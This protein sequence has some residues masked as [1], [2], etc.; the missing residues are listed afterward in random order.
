M[1]T[2]WL[3]GGILALGLGLVILVFAEG[4]RRYYSGLFFIIMGLVL[5]LGLRK[6][7]GA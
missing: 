5:L 2:V 1:R 7:A 4:L 3:V 6:R